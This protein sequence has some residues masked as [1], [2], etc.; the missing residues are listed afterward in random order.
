MD[1]IRPHVEVGNRNSRATAKWKE[2]FEHFFHRTDGMGQRFELWEGDDGWKRFKKAVISA[3]FGYAKA[4]AEN[5]GA[6][7]DVMMHAHLMR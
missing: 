3:V 5:G 7:L 4:Y 6:S 2:L 1:T